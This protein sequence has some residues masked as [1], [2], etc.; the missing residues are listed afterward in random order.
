M[1][2]RFLNYLLN[3]NPNKAV[4][5]YGLMIRK[6]I[7]PLY[8]NIMILFTKGKLVKDKSEDGE[9]KEDK[10]IYACTHSFHDDIVFSMKL[11][12]KHTYLLYGN[13]KD[14]YETFHGIGLW[15]NGVVLVDRNSLSSRKSSIEKMV[16]II[17]N[18]GSIIMFP[19]GTW[20]LN[21]NLPILEL[22]LG[23]YDV[24][25]RTNARIVPIATYQDSNITYSKKGKSIDI[26]EIDEETYSYIIDNQLKLINKCI[27]LLVY[28]TDI[29]ISIKKYL[30][31][32]TS[33]LKEEKNIDKVELYAN[34]LKNKVID[35]KEKLEVHSCLYSI[36]D[37]IENLLSLISK[38][39]KIVCV[40]KLRDILASLKWQ[41]YT[42]KK[43]SDIDNNYWENYKSN[44]IATTNGCYNY[45]EEKKSVY[46]N[47]EK[48]NEDDVFSCLDNI[49]VT[50][51]NA[52]VLML[53]RNK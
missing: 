22:H 17:E 14:F 35:Y 39:K 23:I 33:I 5:K 3:D 15:M 12:D 32:I 30:A 2:N 7:S 43:R 48:Y 40:N 11:A 18:K 42:E 24:V 9:V 38:M 4:S 53:T 20:N 46:I 8:R 49:E 28:N 10:V 16:Y 36:M 1:H 6:F 44:L 21:E 25:K 51:E 19:E 52:R 50:K 45:D 47:P 34:V 31:L 37:R 27:D 13:L 41:L 26:T 29:E